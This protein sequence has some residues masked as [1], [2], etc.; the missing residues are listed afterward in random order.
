M[1]AHRLH[2]FF[3]GIAVL[4]VCPQGASPRGDG[5]ASSVMDLSQASVGSLASAGG[6]GMGDSMSVHMNMSASS[7]PSMTGFTAGHLASTANA[8]G[9]G[10]LGAALRDTKC[11]VREQAQ[12]VLPTVC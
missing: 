1:Q 3:D 2:C 6:F 10:A 4:S 9:A 8:T 5:G 7:L 12:S 11:V